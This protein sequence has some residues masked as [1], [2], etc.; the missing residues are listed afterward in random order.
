MFKYTRAAISYLFDSLKKILYFA[1]VL[2]NSIYIAYLIFTLCVGIGFWFVNAALLAVNIAYLIFFF[3]MEHKKKKAEQDEDKK[4][5]KEAQQTIQRG[6]R[7]FAFFKAMIQV[8]NL[9]I[10]I[11]GIAF[12]G[13]DL[14][15]LNVILVTLMIVF[16]LLQLL[17]IVLG[18]VIDGVKEFVCDAFD[19]DM[20]E[21]KKP[22]RAVGNLFKRLFGQEVTPEPEE[23]KTKKTLDKF[24]EQRQEAA[25]QKKQAKKEKKA[26]AKKAAREAQAA[27]RAKKKAER[28]AAQTAKKA[29]K[30]AKKGNAGQADASVG[31][32]QEAN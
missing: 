24:I 7:L 19:A 10:I 18:Q 22:T 14:P 25:A 27:E 5:N 21:G 28:E 29:A 1:T 20:D 30:A 11:Y 6:N 26:A 8:V 9:G 4:E 3:V 2:G 12:L 13:N 32:P 15:P 31:N 16:L 17:F 23:T